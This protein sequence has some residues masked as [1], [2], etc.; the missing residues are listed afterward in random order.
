MSQTRQGAAS[1]TPFSLNVK[2][3]TRF[4]SAISLTNV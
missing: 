4:C 3:L 2:P 1:A